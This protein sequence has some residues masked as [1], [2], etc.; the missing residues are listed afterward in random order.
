MFYADGGSQMNTGYKANASFTS[1]N[2]FDPAFNLASGFPAYMAPPILNPSYFEGQVVAS[3]YIRSNMNKP[4]MTQQ[5]NLQIQQE[6]APDLIFTIGYAGERGNRLR[7][8]LENI[9][10]IPKSAFALGDNLNR[11]LA[12]NTAG[13]TAPFPTFFSLYGNSVQTAQALRPFPQY[14]AVQTSCCLQ[15]DGQ[16]SYHAL[17]TSLQRRFRNGLNLQV[18]YTWSKNF[19]DADTV[20]LNTN[21]LSAIQDP[22]NLKGEK[23][24]STQDLPNVFVTSFIQEVPFGKNRRYFNHGVASY[25]LGGWQVG[26]VLRYQSG[27][28][29]SFGC[30]ANIPGWDN[31]VRFNQIPGSSFRSAASRNGT[32]NPFNVPAAGANPNTNSLF[33]LNVTRDAQNGAFVDPNASRNGGSYQFGNISRVETALR[34]NGFKNEDFSLIKNTPIREGVDLQLKFEMLN[35]T[36]RHAWGVPSLTPTDTLFGVPTSTL[37]TP[38]NSQITARVRF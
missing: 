11:T 29:L 1:V 18:S 26:A 24:V 21:S 14:Q 8:N 12:S 13:V 6:L 30:A 19:T 23:S 25:A 4:A 15:N 27:T 17:L 36:N 31:C 22:T 32:V 10:N 33:N 28:P 9:N 3:N 37:T 38:R 34:L 5:W 16:S 20:V 7:S 35:A 2:G